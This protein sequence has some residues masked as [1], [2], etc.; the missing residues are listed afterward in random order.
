MFSIWQLGVAVLGRRFA[1]KV[2]DVPIKKRRFLIRSPSPPPRTPSPDHEDSLS[3]QPQTP[4]HPEE[5]EQLFY[6]QHAAAGQWFFQDAHSSNK[7][8]VF[9]GSVG[10]KFGDS[11]DGVWNRKMSEMKNIEHDYDDDFLGIQLLAAAA[12]SSSSIDDDA[13]NVKETSAVEEFMKAEGIDSPSAAIPVKESIASSGT[14]NMSQKDVLNED[15]MG[16]SFVEDST[17]DVLANLNK[18]KNG[19]IVKSSAPSKDE[20]LHWDLNTVMEA[21][22]ESYDDPLA[23]SQIHVSEF[24][25]E[26]GMQ[27]EKFTVGSCEMQNLK[28]AQCDTESEVQSVVCGKALS[29]VEGNKILLDSKSMVIATAKTSIQEDNMKECPSLKGICP[30]KQYVDTPTQHATESLN[31]VFDTIASSDKK[32]NTTASIIEQI[33]EDSCGTSVAQNGTSLY[34]SFQA[35]NQD[36]FSADMPHQKSVCGVDCA[37]Y[38]ICEDFDKSS[39][40]PMPD[41]RTSP[42]QV[43]ISSLTSKTVD[44]KSS[45]GESD[46]DDSFHP[47]PKGEASSSSSTSVVMTSTSVVIGEV[48]RRDEKVSA[49]DSTLKD[50]ALQIGSIELM[51]KCS[52][53]IVSNE[54]LKQGGVISQESCKIFG[55]A[56]VPTN[57]TG[58]HAPENHFS[59]CYGSDVTQDGHVAGVEHVTEHDAGYDSSF[60]DGELREP[61]VYS[62]EENELEGCETECVDYG[63]DDGD[64]DDYDVVDYSL[65]ENLEVGLDGYQIAQKGISLVKNDDTVKNVTVGNRSAIEGGSIRVLE[66]CFK[67]DVLNERSIISSLKAKISGGDQFNEHSK[68]GIAEG[69]TDGHDDKGILAGEFQSRAARGKFT[70]YS[71]GPNSFDVLERKNTL[72]LQRSR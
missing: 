10:L 68:Y 39:G 65:S 36:I 20:R 6:S 4:T 5:S 58:N 50:F 16:V 71:K 61:G 11:V 29:D 45:V 24:V 33:G 35:A 12:C 41:N 13:V 62:W 17:F 21:W 70:S 43:I 44:V 49:T 69:N 57:C 40:L 42:S 23:N 8:C 2:V 67:G 19:G 63:S 26:D 52:E 38:K 28:D 31:Y 66:Q 51:A 22:E 37:Q 32:L 15:N 34:G 25:L 1:E 53:H 3:P 48:K 9:D 59:D 55:D 14:G 7:K 72:P 47:S 46:K 64:A 18:K 54:G 30:E 56:D 27:C 60:E